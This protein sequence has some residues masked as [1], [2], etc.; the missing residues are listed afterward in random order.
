MAFT[1]LDKLRSGLAS[2]IKDA[3]SFESAFSGV[4]KTLNG[5]EADFQQ[6]ESGV[7][8]MSARIPIAVEELGKIGELG[9]QL[10]VPKEALLDFTET[11]AKLG[12]TTNLT[13]EEAATAFAQI[14]SIM[15]IPLAEVSNMG[16][17]V[18]GLGNNFATTESQIV[19][20]SS[21]IAGAGTLVGLTSAD[22]F[23]IAT[24][25]S[26]V[27]IEAE[28]GGTAVS[29]G[30][31]TIQKAVSDGGSELEKF[32]TLTGQTAGEFA[33]NW[34]DSAAE[35]FTE[36]IEGISQAGDK[37]APVIE[38]LFGSSARLFRAFASAATSGDTLRRAIELS[39]TEFEKNVALQEEAQKKFATTENQLLIQENRWRLLGAFLGGQFL[40][41]ITSVTSFFTETIPSVLIK[42]NAALVLL[43]AE[44]ANAYERISAFFA[45][46]PYNA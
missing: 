3:M 34:K 19:D 14:A 18:V 10:G 42:T 28:A 11:V 1:F 45:D 31:I 17:A 43:I 8:A 4:R 24:A 30:L 16:S 26:S 15:Q 40:P 12:V 35:Q 20:F 21:R 29:E 25:F 32:A 6:I 38:S 7:R 23:G 5:S 2:T 22:V 9:A 46:L 33:K 36:V 44:F 41:V 37:A 39:N 13:T 27:G